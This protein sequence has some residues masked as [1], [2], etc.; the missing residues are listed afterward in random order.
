M[1]RWEGGRTGGGGGGGGC[2]VGGGVDGRMVDMH[3]WEG[4]DAQVGV[5]DTRV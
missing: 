1:H 4:V 3:E 2:M 5:V